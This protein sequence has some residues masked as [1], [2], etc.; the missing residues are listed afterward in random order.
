[1]EFVDEKELD[2]F[3]LET[4]RQPELVKMGKNEFKGMEAF[5]ARQQDPEVEEGAI[6]ADFPRVLELPLQPE[7]TGQAGAEENRE[8]VLI[9]SPESRFF[10]VGKDLQKKSI[11]WKG[12]ITVMPQSIIAPSQELERQRKMELYNIVQP[13][14][15][16]IALAMAQGQYQIAL[17][18]AKPVVQI[19]EIQN[20]KSENWLPA[21]VVKLLND[22]TLVG[23][24]TQEKAMAM[25]AAKPLLMDASMV[26]KDATG[27]PVAPSEQAPELPG[28]APKAQVESPVADTL[29]EI[30]KVPA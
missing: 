11:K 4:G 20:E 7:Q 6:T 29:S 17:D 21:D 8:G 3:I 12:K 18:T 10:V 1:M 30:G 14:V 26:G 23:K 24:M 16:T 2:E 19:L 9:E 28:I 15:A 22:P 25:N 5:T 13:V 27:K